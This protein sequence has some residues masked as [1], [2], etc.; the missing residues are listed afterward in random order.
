LATKAVNTD[1]ILRQPDEFV[2]AQTAWLRL[3]GKNVTA[4]MELQLRLPGCCSPFEVW[5]EQMK[6]IQGRIDDTNDIMKRLAR[7]VEA[8]P[9]R[10]QRS[11]ATQGRPALRS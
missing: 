5:S 6:F 8:A 11:A 9:S 4:L 10:L 1:A 2:S 3:I 7:S